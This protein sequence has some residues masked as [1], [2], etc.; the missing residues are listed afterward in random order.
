VGAALS[1]IPATNCA[2][3]TK[4][5]LPLSDALKAW[6][7]M[8]FWP[9]TRYVEG[10]GS[11][12]VRTVASIGADAVPLKATLPAGMLWR[13]TSTPLIHAMNPSSES[14][15][16]SMPVTEPGVAMLK[17]LRRKTEL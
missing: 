9:A 16:N 17:V 3:M 10:F 14:D 11:V 8:V 6:M 15:R 5:A 7:A 12:C 2:S 4:S 13:A 1:A